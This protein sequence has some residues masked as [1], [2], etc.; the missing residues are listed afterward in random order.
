MVYAPA[1]LLTA[2]LELHHDVNDLHLHAGGQGVWQ[3]RM[4]TLLGARAV[5][6]TVLGGETGRVLEALLADEVFAVRSVRRAHATGWYVHD[7]RQ[8]QRHTI[9]EAAG[10]P[11]DR[12]VVDELYNIALAE[13]LRAPVT[14]LGGPA[15]P[16]LLKPDVYRRLASDLTANGTKV[17]ADLA[18]EHLTAALAGGVAVLKVSHDEIIAAGRAEDSGVEALGTAARR[19]REEGAQAVV[20]SRAHEPALALLDGTLHLVEPPRIEEVDPRGAGDSM[21]A[22]I[23]TLLARGAD[24][25]T[26]I[27]VGTAAGAVNVTRHGLGTG[28]AD[29]IAEL[30]RRVRLTPLSGAAS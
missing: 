23:A 27:R 7:R 28:H 8:G 21:T 11:L 5:L 17:V 15:H 4:V 16:S 29:A 22:G 24:L 2:T 26:A 25:E 19:L 12:H 18:G 13:G 9:A 20:I 6:C 1:P 10:T 30:A 3:A 14:L